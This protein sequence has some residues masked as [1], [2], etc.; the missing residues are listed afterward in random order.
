MGQTKLLRGSADQFVL[1]HLLSRQFI[2]EELLY[3]RK[4]RGG[5]YRTENA[6]V[7]PV[8]GKI[9]LDISRDISNVSYSKFLCISAMISCGTLYNTMLIC[10]GSEFCFRLVR[11]VTSELATTVS[12]HVLSI[13]LFAILPYTSTVSTVLVSGVVK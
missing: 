8:P 2:C 7:L 9:S 6:L 3:I 11:R 10:G 12:F 1:K 4:Q 5:C 13:S